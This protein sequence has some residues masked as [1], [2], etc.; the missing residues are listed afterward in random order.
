MPIIA[1]DEG[2]LICS[3]LKYINELRCAETG[4]VYRMKAPY[5]EPRPALRGQKISRSSKKDEN[6]T[7]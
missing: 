1:E 3:T 2:F 6:V 5:S 7:F 4:S